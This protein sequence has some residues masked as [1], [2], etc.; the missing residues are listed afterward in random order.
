MANMVR[1]SRVVFQDIDADGKPLGPLV[2]GVIFS[3][4]YASD[5]CAAYDSLKD[6]NQNVAEHGMLDLV[7]GTERWDN[8]DADDPRWKDTYHGPASDD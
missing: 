7:G 1:C 6:L 4:D 5:Y 3:D 8:L 2:Y